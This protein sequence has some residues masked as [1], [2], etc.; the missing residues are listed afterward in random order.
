MHG[1]ASSYIIVYNILGVHRVVS[2]FWE[3]TMLVNVS[4]LNGS[5]DNLTS[6]K[7]LVSIQKDIK[8]FQDV[9]AIL[10][11][12]Y[13]DK[14]A[15]YPIIGTVTGTKEGFLIPDIGSNLFWI[16]IIPN[17]QKPL[18]LNDFGIPSSS[19]NNE[20]PNTTKHNN[21]LATLMRVCQQCMRRKI[22]IWRLA[23]ILSMRDYD[24]ATERLIHFYVHYVLSH[25]TADEDTSWLGAMGNFYNIPALH[26]TSQYCVTI[27][28][29]SLTNNNSVAGQLENHLAK[30]CFPNGLS[31]FEQ[32]FIRKLVSMFLAN[33]DVAYDSQLVANKSKVGVT[34]K[35]F[36]S[37]WK[38]INNLYHKNFTSEAAK[39]DLISDRR[40]LKH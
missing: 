9:C 34:Q 7:K 38:N 30:N 23:S 1:H 39:Y 15:P 35:Q 2:S 8:N 5:A 22:S 19:D 17:M 11:A 16:S 13:Q 28:M 37:L 29:S 18:L 4:C 12:I 27:D 25:C 6:I 21:R 20:A 36:D 3:V 14:K 10:T 31:R 26:I 33:K 24:T 40:G 32:T